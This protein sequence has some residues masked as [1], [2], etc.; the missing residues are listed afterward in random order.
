SGLTFLKF[1]EGEWWPWALIA[2]GIGTFWPF[3][4]FEL[5]QKDPAID[6]RVL[7]QPNMWPVQLTAF[8]IGISLLGAQAPLATYAGTDP[9]ELVD[10]EPLGYGLGLPAGTISILIGAYLISMI[11]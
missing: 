3:V 8:L 7:R 9:T 11:V 10:G 4:A 6:I 1:N 2:L 5:R